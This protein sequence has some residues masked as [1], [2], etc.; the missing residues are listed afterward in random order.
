M[1]ADR[2]RRIRD[3]SRSLWRAAPVAA[4]VGLLIA[5]TC[6]WTGFSAWPAIVFFVSAA[7]AF[8]GLAYSVRRERGLSDAS[9]ARTDADAGFSGEIRSAG[10][11]A[12]HATPDPWAAFHLERAAE[13][14]QS[15]DWTAFYPAAPATRSKL[16]AAAL[17][18]V[19]ILVLS[20]T[21]APG[22]TALMDRGVLG[23]ASPAGTDI[24]GAET[25]SPELLKQIE[26]LLAE[27]EAGRLSGDAAAGT[28]DALRNL[29]ARLAAEGDRNRGGDRS[30]ASPPLSRGEANA[31]ARRLEALAGRAERASR[32][33]GATPQVRESLES[34]ADKLNRAA[35]AQQ[36]RAQGAPGAEP[37]RNS[38]GGAAG[39]AA[40]APDARNDSA[41]ASIQSST[42]SASGGGAGV[43]MMSRQ[44]GSAGAAAPG[45]GSSNT[46]NRSAGRGTMA[47]IARALRHE[48]LEASQDGAGENIRT[49]SRR[50]TEQGHASTAFTRGSAGVFDRGGAAGSPA[51]PEE[52]R[53]AVRGY[54]V[55]RQ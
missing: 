10:W 52:R 48:V 55:R 54:F 11:F 34:L 19:S 2:R 4:A 20:T 22:T 41:S 16:L 13:R 35:N 51:V 26:D 15:I 27:A 1:L 53:A 21:S 8:I 17:T 49:E 36:A 25:L 9:A 28:A 45:A 24:A 5:A 44:D 6:R 42:E 3:R 33:A 46:G 18:A 7:V 50:Q 14:L 30:N 47:D 29:L 12:G 32:A 37:G 40:S 38:E 23:A 39:Q 43:M 31:L